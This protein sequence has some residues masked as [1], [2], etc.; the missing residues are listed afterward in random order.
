MARVLQAGVL[1]TV[2]YEKSTVV[3]DTRTRATGTGQR[4][5][6]GMGKGNAK[7]GCKKILTVKVAC[8]TR[9]A[10]SSANSDAAVWRVV[11]LVQTLRHEQV[12]WTQY[13]EHGRKGNVRCS[14]CRENPIR[15]SAAY[16]DRRQLVGKMFAA[17]LRRVEVAARQGTGM[18]QRRVGIKVSGQL[19]RSGT[20]FTSQSEARDPA[21]QTGGV[22]G[23]H[24]MRP[25][26][27]TGD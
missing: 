8:Q 2:R 6:V 25:S 4:G 13:C 14:S 22:Y 12:S 11:G 16:A 17:S 20:G 21:T 10:T 18:C 23:Q 3:V 5:Q 15:A 26:R 24:A 19:I 7:V 27:G 9:W 1:L